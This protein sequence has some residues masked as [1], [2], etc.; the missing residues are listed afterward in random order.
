MIRILYICTPSSIHDIKWM[1][2]FS[3]Q[4]EKYEVCAIYES[5]MNISAEDRDVLSK[6]NIKLLEPIHPFSTST[7]LKTINS[8]FRLRKAIKQSNIDLVHIL[9]ATPHALW[10]NFISVP[11]IITTRGSDVLIVIPELLKRAGIKSIYYRVLFFLFKRAFRNAA[12]LTA[13]STKQLLKIQQLFNRKPILI[14][15]GVSVDE[16]KSINNLELLP[17]PLL[18]QPFIFSP[19]FM[20][21]I[22]NIALQID[23]LAYLNDSL[24]EKYLFVF[25]KGKSFNSGYYRDQFIRLESLKVQRGLHYLIVDYFE[26]EALWMAF[27]KASLTIMTPISDGTP[28]SALEAMA[29]EC[30][31]IIP[32]LDYDKDIFDNATY[33]FDK[34]KPQHLAHL[35]EKALTYYPDD[36]IDLASERVVKHGNRTIEMKRL[37]EIYE[38]ILM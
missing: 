14:K 38:S 19:R 28:N 27:K 16:I 15:T 23:A 8:I 26:Q 1:S 25:V 4:K 7:P 12:S 36:M 24:L 17:L 9:F 30:P 35:I 32:D 29:A 11:Y 22:Y 31:L 2:F 3:M 33:V 21:P 13:T 10:G 5:N 6:L 37:E 34:V 20:S 18:K